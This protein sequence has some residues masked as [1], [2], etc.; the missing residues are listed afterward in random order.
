MSLF[1][2]ALAGALLLT[3]GYFAGVPLARPQEV[4]NLTGLPAYPN[5]ATAAMDSVS[6]TDTLGR[7]CT[8]FS[9]ETTDPLGAVENWYRKAL[10]RA[11]ETDLTHDET[12]K[13]YPLLIGIKL[14]V[15]VDSVTVYKV[16][17][18]ARTSIEL[19]RCSAFP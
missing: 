3:I 7:W 13:I 17:P 11:S 14:S 15:G 5:L 8:R 18:Q 2:N 9:G 10:V 6:R 1:E 16:D 4:Q 19:F 12:Y